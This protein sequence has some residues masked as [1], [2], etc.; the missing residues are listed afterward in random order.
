M[1]N[2][3]FYIQIRMGST[4]FPGKVLKPISNDLTVVDLLYHRL[5]R[6]QCAD[7][8]N[9][10]FLTTDNHEDDELEDYFKNR[11]WNFFRGSETNV[12]LR[13]RETCTLYPSLFFFR[14]C[15]DNPFLEPALLDKLALQAKKHPKYDYLS[16][17]ENH[18][19]VIKSHYGFFGE[20]IS[21]HTFLNIKEEDL[22]SRTT[23]H[24]TSVFYENPQ[25]FKIKWLEIPKALQSP[26]IRLT[27]DTIE[28]LDIIRKLF[29]KLK[30]NFHIYDVYDQ[31][32]KETDLNDIMK[33]QIERNRK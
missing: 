13:F 18:K 21:M 14:I 17:H 31:L 1:N 27:V 7:P 26:H 4:R 22:N 24:V 9:I 32:K 29:A 5:L 8:E 25:E 11:H 28:D 15:A 10:I 23:E 6:C 19:P 2:F 16:Y 33:Q 30:P 12:F 20:L 3:V